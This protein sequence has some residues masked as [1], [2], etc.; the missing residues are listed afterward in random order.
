MTVAISLQWNEDF[1]PI[2]EIT[3]P[4]ISS[5][6]VKHG[7]TLYLH[8]CEQRS[9]EIVWQRIEDFRMMMDGHD[10]SVH[11]DCD[12]LI[13]NS[14]ITIEE[15]IGESTSDFITGA[16]WN[17]INDGFSL[18]RKSSKSRYFLENFTRAFGGRY[19]SPQEV[20]NSA[21]KQS[22]NMEVLPQRRVNSYL[23]KEYGMT[24]LDAEWQPGDFALH[25]PGLSNSRRVE[26]LKQFTA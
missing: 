20:L 13:T 5:Y 19:S 25:L 9:P 18:W 8:K 17:G 14:E 1:R 10:V 7:Y 22:V 12:Y 15:I 23:P 21:M 6:A 11:M 16:D 3:L 26:I 4:V 24:N 2:A